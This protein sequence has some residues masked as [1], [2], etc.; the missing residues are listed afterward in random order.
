[1]FFALVAQGCFD[2]GFGWRCETLLHTYAK[3]LVAIRTRLPGCAEA[4]KAEVLVSQPTE[5]RSDV[6][7]FLKYGG[8]C[9]LICRPYRVAG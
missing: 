7:A 1:L 6:P 8:Y 5:F 9:G 2:P 3:E 4:R